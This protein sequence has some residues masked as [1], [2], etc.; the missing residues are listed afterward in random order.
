MPVDGFPNLLR[1]APTIGPRPRAVRK[2]I[3]STITSLMRPSNEEGT[4]AQDEA[5]PSSY[6]H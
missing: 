2:T 1:N 5:A 3:A 4:N 6:G